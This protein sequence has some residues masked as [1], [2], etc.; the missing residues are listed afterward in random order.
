MTRSERKMW[1]EL[2]R[3]QKKAEANV[4]QEYKETASTTPSGDDY[5]D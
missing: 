3:A 5:L 1:V 2:I 4:T